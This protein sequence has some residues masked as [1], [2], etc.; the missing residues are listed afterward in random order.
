VSAMR[1]ASTYATHSR[2]S[3]RAFA[4]GDLFDRREVDCP[5]NQLAMRTHLRVEQLSRSKGRAGQARIRLCQTPAKSCRERTAAG[6]R[7]RCPLREGGASAAEAR[8]GEAATKHD[9][10]LQRARDQRLS[11]AP[12]ARHAPRP[13]GRPRSASSAR[14]DTC[15]PPLTSS[16]GHAARDRSPR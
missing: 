13:L 1:S 6:G 4:F 15:W 3:L 7:R 14:P 11:T 16:D 8:C 9:F 5:T 12:A 10:H 2:R